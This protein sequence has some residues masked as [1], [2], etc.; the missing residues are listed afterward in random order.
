LAALL[1]Q[2]TQT[3]PTEQPCPDC[4][5]PCSVTHEPRELDSPGGTVVYRE[6]VCK[7]PACRRA[8]F[9]STPDAAPRRPSL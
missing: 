7:C 5:R 9:P 6:P 8:F 3:L 1:E 2:Q 4:G